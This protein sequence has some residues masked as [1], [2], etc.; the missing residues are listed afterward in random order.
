MTNEEI[1][2]TLI[3]L[4]KAE[5]DFSVTQTSKFFKDIGFQELNIQPEL[6]L[7]KDKMLSIM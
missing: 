2:Q 7:A 6:F 4:E 3:S 1:K 5:I